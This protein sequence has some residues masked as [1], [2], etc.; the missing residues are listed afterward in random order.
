[1][2]I[3]DNID[4]ENNILEAESNS[5]QNRES[6]NNHTDGCN[7]QNKQKQSI[8]Q[9]KKGKDTQIS[10]QSNTKTEDE[11]ELQSDTISE[12]RRRVII[13]KKRGTQHNDSELNDQGKKSNNNDLHVRF[14]DNSEEMILDKEPKRKG[15]DNMNDYRDNQDDDND[16]ENANYIVEKIIK[17]RIKNKK[18]EYLVKWQG[19]PS[20]K[21]TW[22]SLQNLENVKDMIYQY[23]Y[24]LPQTGK[25]PK[26][27]KKI[28]KNLDHTKIER[29]FGHDRIG[30]KSQYLVSYT[31]IPKPLWVLKNDLPISYYK[32][33][34]SKLSA[35]DPVCII[36]QIKQ[37]NKEQDSF[38]KR[39]R[40]ASYHSNEIENSISKKINNQLFSSMDEEEDDQSYLENQEPSQQQ[41]GD[42]KRKL[43]KKTIISDV[44]SKDS[45]SI[46][47]YIVS[48]QKKLGR[49]K[50]KFIQDSQNSSMINNSQIEDDSTLSSKP[51][52]KVKTAQQEKLCNPSKIQQD[53]SSFNQSNLDKLSDSSQAAPKNDQPFL[54]KRESNQDPQD[55]AQ[56]QQKSLAESYPKEGN[57][58]A[59]DKVQ[60]VIIRSSEKELEAMIFEVFWKPRP[61]GQQPRSKL[62]RYEE[63]KKNSPESLIYWLEVMVKN[64]VKELESD[65]VIIKD[66]KEK[67]QQLEQQIQ[68][69]A[70]PTRQNI[71]I[72][73]INLPQYMAI[74][75][76]IQF[77]HQ[78][79]QEMPFQSN[80][81]Q[82]Q[83]NKI[84]SQFYQELKLSQ[85]KDQK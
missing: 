73:H 77:Q 7:S 60:R 23:E 67:V 14:K 40:K 1:M 4:L 76:N 24:D 29:I 21:N 83:K 65:D 31:D 51:K 62:V 68:N 9:G 64:S 71:Q 75:Q 2:S 35:S 25:Q 43:I 39:G 78:Q 20:N 81:Q 27:S 79:L 47:Q 18:C 54:V 8:N 42:K 45:N 57:F 33:Y 17:K 5:G 55:V 32:Q 84:N 69:I 44:E 22:E 50:K 30:K 49:P 16:E 6:I 36:Q 11:S 46:P 13:K 74:P 48:K 70:V 15:D 12:D 19:Y 28:L 85:Q 80:Q 53:S 63:L 58:E 26:V 37:T 41:V 66:L 10:F 38:Q 59:K 56:T 52:K 82:F 3:Q 34:E 72:P 61:D